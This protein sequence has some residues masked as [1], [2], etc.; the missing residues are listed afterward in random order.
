MH[1][2]YIGGGTHSLEPVLHALESA[3]QVKES[4]NLCMVCWSVYF[5]VICI[6]VFGFFF[7]NNQ[8]YQENVKKIS[9]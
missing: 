6:N 3:D 4:E 1:T 2:S 9:H 7:L 8:A 5:V